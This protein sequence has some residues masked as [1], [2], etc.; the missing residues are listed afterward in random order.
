[1]QNYHRK[2]KDEMYSVKNVKTF[3]GSDCPG[4]ACSLY[5]EGRRVATVLDAGNGGCIDYT[6]NDKKDEAEF[7]SYVNQSKDP[8][9]RILDYNDPDCLLYLLVNDYMRKKDCKKWTLFSVGEGEEI[10]HLMIKKKYSPE[11]KKFLEEK[12]KDR[13]LNILNEEIDTYRKRIVDEEC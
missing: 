11:I 6:F 5:K 4:Y 13:Y 7:Y 9:L 10:E 3:M 12:Y 8:N 2:K 1:M